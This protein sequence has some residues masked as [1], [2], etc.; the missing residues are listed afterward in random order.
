MKLTDYINEQ[1]KGNV[2]AFA[3][4]QDVGV[5]QAARWVKRGCKWI[6]GAV[7]CK[8]SKHKGVDNE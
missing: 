1:H 2:S 8:V 3:R 7:W 5:T 6:D 4:S